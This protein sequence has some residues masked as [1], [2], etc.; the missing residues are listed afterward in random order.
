M[1]QFCN[2]VAAHPSTNKA[3]VPPPG[4]LA[5]QSLRFSI[6]YSENLVTCLLS[7]LVVSSSLNCSDFAH[8]V[9][10]NNFARLVELENTV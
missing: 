3:E 8:L 6:L 10:L 4:S 9:G 1:G 2:S 5:S 7:K